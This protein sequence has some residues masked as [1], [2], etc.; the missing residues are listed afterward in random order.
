MGLPFGDLCPR[1]HYCP[2]GTGH[3]R[4]RPCPAGTWNGQRGARDVTWCLPCA[5]GFFCNI[6]GQAAPGGL[7]AQGEARADLCSSLETGFDLGR[8]TP[9]FSVF[10]LLLHREDKDCKAR[11]WSHWRSLSSRTFL[12]CR[13]SSTFPLPQRG[14]Q[15]CHR[16]G[17]A[18]M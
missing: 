17:D 14:I 1:G 8:R 15:Q 6:S 3:P 16:S 7:C 11:G 5:P 10:R 12:P 13:L 4:A 18:E 9:I 2:A